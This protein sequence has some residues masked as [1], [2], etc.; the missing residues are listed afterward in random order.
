MAIAKPC[1]GDSSIHRLESIPY[2]LNSTSASASGSSTTTRT[3]LPESS[4]K[5][6]RQ[7]WRIEQKRAIYESIVDV[8]NT[9]QV[10]G[11]VCAWPLETSGQP[12]K[13]CG[14]IF[15]LLDYLVGKQKI[16]RGFMIGGCMTHLDSM[17]WC[18]ELGLL[19]FVLSSQF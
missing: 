1:H 16:E 17:I 10:T 19:T 3:S 14:Q 5:E 9:H 8:A 15:H 18:T 2:S 4:H 11:F 6:Q 12:G 13:S 7:K